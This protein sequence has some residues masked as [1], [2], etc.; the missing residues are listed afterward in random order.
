MNQDDFDLL[1]T[2]AR[3][4]LA[5]SPA[6]TRGTLQLVLMLD[7]RLA[8]LVA[9]TT[10]PML[11]QMRLAWWRDMF[12]QPAAMRPRGDVV[13]DGIS[14]GWQGS[15]APLVGLVDGWENLIADPPLPSEA[16][17]ACGAGR[18][19]ALVAA[20]GYVPGEP[21]LEDAEAAARRWALGDLAARVSDPQ[22]RAML[23]GLGQAE[24]TAARTRLGRKGSGLAVLDA[25]AR[26]SLKRG[27]RPLMEGRGAAAAAMTAAIFCK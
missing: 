10:E 17:L 13:L 1:A 15:Y 5:Y 4:A 11:G 18:A 26:R 22:E 14:Q 9:R 8:R 16:A 27:A 21:G 12:G 23:I 6:A 7:Q 20:C 3:L 24:C 25:L 19:G 2:E